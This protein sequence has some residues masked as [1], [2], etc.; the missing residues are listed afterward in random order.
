MPPS[1]TRYVQNIIPYS[2]KSP[3]Y[4]YPICVNLGEYPLYPHPPPGWRSR[5]FLCFHFLHKSMAARACLD[6]FSL[7]FPFSDQDGDRFDRN[8]E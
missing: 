2:R 1:A 6:E 7:S 5:F 8:E 3:E 4:I